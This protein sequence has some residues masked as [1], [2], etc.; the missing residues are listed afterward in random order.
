MCGDFLH[1]SVVYTKQKKKKNNKKKK[2]WIRLF[3]ENNGATGI[4]WII[5][6]VA[7]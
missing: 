3:G 2:E 1:F 6:N 4:R 7:L 5:T